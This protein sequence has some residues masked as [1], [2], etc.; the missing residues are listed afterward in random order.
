[1]KFPK[2]PFGSF[3]PPP[4]LKGTQSRHHVA[5][6]ASGRAAVSVTGGEG[7]AGDAPQ[8]TS[9]RGPQIKDQRCWRPGGPSPGPLLPGPLGSALGDAR[10]SCAR[11]SNHLPAST[12][13]GH[14]P[15][16]HGAPAGS[17]EPRRPQPSGREGP[18]PG[19]GFLAPERRAL[20]GTRPLAPAHSDHNGLLSTAGSGPVTR[21]RNWGLHASF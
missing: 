13:P 7:R 21:P 17:Q 4:G 8:S 15:H 9:C 5:G 20:E 12:S 14:S 19:A 16:G 2:V 1:M 10:G 3:S 6:R 18:C 11:D